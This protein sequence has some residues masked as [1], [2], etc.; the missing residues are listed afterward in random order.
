MTRQFL[1]LL[2]IALTTV[3]NAFS[4]D[5]TISGTLIDKE[6]KEA[7]I[8]ATIQLLKA[9][10]STYVAGTVSNEEGIFSMKTPEPGKYIIKMTNIGYKQILRNITVSEGKDFAFGKISMET[11]AVLLKEVI[12]NGVAAKVI[13]KEDTFIYNAAAYR[14]PE[15]SVIE[16]LVKRLPGAQVSDDGKITINGKEVKKV[17]VDGKEFMTGDTQTALK[18]LPTAIIDKVKAYDEK[19]DL[20]RMTGVDDGEEQ[21]VLDFNIKR[22]M[23]KGFLSNIDLA[24]GTEKR[25]AERVMA[26]YMKDESRVMVFG[27]ANN[28]GDRGFSSG[29]RRGGGGGNGLQANKMLGINYNYEKKDK[30]RADFSVRWNHGDT[31]NY[32][33]TA[34]ENFVSR[35]G[36]FSNSLSQNYSRNNSWNMSGRLEWKP[37]TMTTIQVRPS[38]STSTNDSRGQSLNASFNKDPYSL[39]D[40]I[41]P[42]DEALMQAYNKSIYDSSMG[43]D[44]LLINRRE[45]RTL[46][47]GSST[48]FNVTATFNRR[49]SSRGNSLTFQGRYSTSNSD[50]E[51][52]ST[53]EVTLYRPTTADSIYY[54]NRY[55][56][57]PSKNWNFQTSLS[58]TER[59]SKFSFL[60][61]KYLYRYSNRTSDRST[62]DFSESIY[63]A[64]GRLIFSPTDFMSRFMDIPAYRSF[65]D[66]LYDYQPLNNS[67]I[68]YSNDKSRYSEYD[69]YTH[70]IELTWRRTTNN[71]NLNLGFLIQPQSQKLTY[72]Y[73]NIDTIAK[74]SVTNVTPTLDFRYRFNKQKSLRL[75]YRG[76]T[77]QPSMTDLLPIVDDTDPLN[78]TMGNPYLKPSF[79]QTFSLRFNNYVQSHFSSVMAFI[80][81][82]NTSNSVS[83][84]VTYDEKTGGR[85]TQPQN[86]DGNWNINSAFMYNASIDTVGVWNFNS[87]SNIRYDNRVNYVNINKTSVAEKNYTRT[88]ALSERLGLSYRNEWLEVELN[89]A[90]E[91]TIS[92]NKLQQ[93]SNLDTWNYQYGADI[94]ITAPWG[95]GLSTGGHMSSRRGYSDASANTDEFIWNAQISQ[96]FLKGKPLTVSLQFYDILNEKSSFTRNIDANSRRDSWYNNINSYAML[97]AIYRF[98]AFGG[99]EARQARQGGDREGGPGEGP[100][101]RGGRGDRMGGPGMGGP[102]GMGGGGMRGGR[103]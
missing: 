29:G 12:A 16:E 90:V 3:E 19:S 101:G 41:D 78:I 85:T 34:T 22:G 74:R 40:N 64:T 20:A 103:F 73:L 23:N 11:D 17:M 58:Y 67:S 9:S 60:V 5:N 92:R 39:A 48:Q 37:D 26:G 80:N 36:S 100:G 84:M 65:S 21:M 7:V 49:L 72:K 68:F 54:K 94:T 42:M 95:T 81:Y 27:N 25:Y 15:G 14:T 4:Q 79:T 32:T 30:L 38:F 44:S 87:F 18:N 93:N 70:E 28:T 69:N 33:R 1:L 75:N 47:Y 63:D 24:I 43:N 13:V 52:L 91:Y 61:L 50:S 96:S 89:G 59:L 8:Q 2:I 76:N 55:N 97:H 86:I 98:N 83:N 56:V 71:Y 88:T 66:Y 6:T 10:D 57:T 77:D 31:D 46:S 35:V 102:G 51:S 53:Q 82:S 99:K 45:N 62:Y